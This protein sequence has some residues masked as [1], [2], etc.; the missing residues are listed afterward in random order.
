MAPAELWH[1]TFSLPSYTALFSPPEHSFYASTLPCTA[2]LAIDRALSKS[3]TSVLP[4]D[5][6]TKLKEELAEILDRGD[7]ME[8]TG[9]EE[10]GEKVF[11]Y[12][13]R[14]EV[15]VMRRKW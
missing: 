14:T 7:G 3:Y 9:E 12:P 5:E 13:Y 11:H 2:S 6:K 1:K 4:E 15:V 8:F 10:N